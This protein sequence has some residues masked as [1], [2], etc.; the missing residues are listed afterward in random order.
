MPQNFADG[1]LTPRDP[2]P[3]ELPSVAVLG[4]GAIGKSLLKGLTRPSVTVRG[5]IRATCSSASRARELLSEFPQVAVASVE[6][7]LDGNRKAVQDA[8]LVVLAVS[9]DLVPAVAAAISDSLKPGA[10]VVSVAAGVTLGALQEML[11]ASGTVIRVLPNMGGD[12]GFGVTGL[13]SNE[14]STEQQL[15]ATADLFRTIGTVVTVRDDQLDAVSSLSGSGP[16]Y[17]YFFVEQLTASGM[18]LGFS[19]EQARVLA[20]QTFLGS[21]ALMHSSGRPPAELLGYFT[22]PDGT[23]IRALKQ[24]ADAGF[25]ETLL[26]AASASMARAR[27]IAAETGQ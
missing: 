13:G 27:D 26:K 20:E 23:S 18:E 3:I 8:E 22:A 14:R 9:P 19:H 17:F 25:K 12:V 6:E 5:A 21:A 10:L 11:P 7:D 1:P 2:D 24:L 16:G 4:A 15:E